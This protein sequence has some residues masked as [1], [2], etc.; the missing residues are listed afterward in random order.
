MSRTEQ[1]YAQIEK[2]VFCIIWASECF[3]DCI[4]GLK[5]HIE[6]DHKSLVPLLSIKNLNELP[7]RVQCF[8]MRMI[9]FSYS[10]SHIPGKI[11]V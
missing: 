3:A 11:L 8:W 5:F 4:I 10:I 1:H 6:T 9:Q 7:A 2:E